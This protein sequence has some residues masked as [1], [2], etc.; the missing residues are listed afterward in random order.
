[1][2][3]ALP[4]TAPIHIITPDSY[5]PVEIVDHD[6]DFNFQGLSPRFFGSSATENRATLSASRLRVSSLSCSRSPFRDTTNIEHKLPYGGKERSFSRGSNQPLS[7]NTTAVPT[8]HSSP[9]PTRF[10]TKPTATRPRGRSDSQRKVNL[11]LSIKPPSTHDP[12]SAYPARVIPPNLPRVGVEECRRWVTNSPSA[13]W[14][15]I[16]ARDPGTSAHTTITKKLPEILERAIKDAEYVL[17]D[18]VAEQSLVFLHNQLTLSI[19]DLNDLDDAVRLDDQTKDLE[20]CIGR[21]RT[22]LHELRSNSVL[23]PIEDDGGNDVRSWNNKLRRII[24][25]EG[26][27]T[28]LD[29]PILFVEGYVYRRLRGCFALSEDWD[30]FDVF[31]NT[32]RQGFIKSAVAV[33]ELSQTLAEPFHAGD[34]VFPWEYPQKLRDAFSDL[35]NDC[36]P[37]PTRE[38]EALLDLTE[39]DLQASPNLPPPRRSPTIHIEDEE[40]LWKRLSH[41]YATREARVDIVL[42]DGGFELFRDLALAD[43]MIQTGLANEVHFHGKP[44][45]WLVSNATRPDW[46][47]LLESLCDRKLFPYSTSAE[48]DSLQ[49]L[50]QRWKKYERE[51][52]FVYEEHSFWCTGLSYWDL[53][54]HAP[55]LFSRLTTSSLII[56]KGEMNYC[57]LTAGRYISPET[58]FNTAIGPMSTHPRV[59]PVC[60]LTMG[61]GSWTMHESELVQPCYTT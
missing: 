59:P 8:R 17:E 6:E 18:L 12:R 22:L 36:I 35:L 61:T 16:R 15:V 37:D 38:Y 54:T 30:D 40:Q 5:S 46:D 26:N 55:E 7:G 56:F 58:P 3:S 4:N 14:P 1:M 25:M 33:L 27:C 44:F 24:R 23:R 29:G 13:T 52:S 53:P 48:R 32:K 49:E 11:S 39:S 51:G 2:L 28:Y 43:F 19:S 45:P 50:G 57:K 42:N 10:R 20:R 9:V 47:W 34:C 21:I 31:T 60:S 41:N